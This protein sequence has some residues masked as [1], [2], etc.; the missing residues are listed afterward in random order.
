M[1]VGAG[2]IGAGLISA[3]SA[4]RASDQAA[5]GSERAAEAI[6]VAG[7]DARR[8]VLDLFPL[9]Q[10]D[11]LA[12]AGGAFDIFSQGIR[13]QQQA[14]GQG[15]MQAQQT[16]GQG[17]DQVRNAL[18]GLPVDQSSFAPRN[19]GFSQ[20]PFNPFTSG[21]GRFGSSGGAGGGIGAAPT[22][23]TGQGSFEDTRLS[24]Q[25]NSR[26]LN[27]FA[28]GLDAAGFIQRD[29]NTGIPQ[30]DFGG[31]QNPGSATTVN[32]TPR[33]S[34]GSFAFN[35]ALQSQREEEARALQTVAR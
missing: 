2:V 35:R 25:P 31:S 30:I 23:Q 29:S 16:V 4:N 18:L 11:L 9:A 33:S 19:V 27:P 10:R 13:G 32:D 14:L 17:F 3:N 21:G 1:P 28:S 26:F 24:G 7:S 22:F 20:L 5:A 8:D 12:G 15:N 34:L 6:R